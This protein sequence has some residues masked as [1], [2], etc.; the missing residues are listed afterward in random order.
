MMKSL[1]EA[2][3]MG[4]TIIVNCTQCGGLMLVAKVQKTK[5]CPYCGTQVNLLKAKKIASAGTAMEASEILRKIK[6][7]Q[8][9]NHI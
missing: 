3:L 8:K 4:V 9:V 1:S 6:G 5:I 7:E 2:N